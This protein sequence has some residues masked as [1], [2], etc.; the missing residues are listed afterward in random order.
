MFLELPLLLWMCS[1][2]L[3]GLEHVGAHGGL[4]VTRNVSVSVVPTVLQVINQSSAVTDGT[5]INEPDFNS[6]ASS[7]DMF[8]GK[9]STIPIKT[10]SEPS[11]KSKGNYFV[12]E[13]S[14]SSD[15]VSGDNTFEN[16]M[17]NVN[18]GTSRSDPQTGP[19][20]PGL[21]SGD[22]T[23]QPQGQSLSVS[24]GQ[25]VNNSVS[26][27]TENYFT[28]LGSP[29]VVHPSKPTPSP[30]ITLPGAG[31]INTTYNSPI[32]TENN[33]NSQTSGVKTLT[34]TDFTTA[35]TSYENTALITQI[36]EH[37]S[38]QT[39]HKG[40]ADHDKSN[41]MSTNRQS[42]DAKD[43]VNNTF[44]AVTENGTK[45]ITTSGVFMTSMSEGMLN[46]STSEDSVVTSI[47]GV[48]R[49]P[50]S[51]T[52][53]FVTTQVPLS[54]KG[55][56]M[57]SVTE[58]V[59]MPESTKTY[60]MLN[61][62]Q[63]VNISTTVAYSTNKISVHSSQ[64]S[65]HL[66]DDITAQTMTTSPGSTT[67][68]ITTNLTVLS[69]LQ[70][71]NTVTSH[72]SITTRPP[73]VTSTELVTQESDGAT[74]LVTTYSNIV[75]MQVTRAKD[76]STTEESF[77]FT[78]D[79][80]TYNSSSTLGTGGLSKTAQ[81]GIGI[82]SVVLFWII[83]GPLV[84][85]ICRLRDRAKAR[86]E[87]EDDEKPRESLSHN[88]MEQYIMTELARGREKM[89]QTTLTN[90]NEIHKLNDSSDYE[91]SVDAEITSF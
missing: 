14:G 7:K 56:T 91:Q 86:D 59:T 13:K 2:I 77:T 65:D 15:T 64:T 34:P 80:S 70:K 5:A 75:T 54:S 69:T 4:S 8:S 66:G 53:Q 37:V 67:Q 61:T 45:S 11:E 10:L 41:N 62:S 42:D 44:T 49:K 24:K 35:S 89:Y 55:Q 71:D 9:T 40:E 23:T 46:N 51:N 3:L 58:N 50:D 52:S 74:N 87:P 57:Q 29:D 72:M 6:S 18:N 38:R 20:T 73:G 27:D 82:G 90:E 48:T 21:S 30:L 43:A 36:S 16:D 19:M 28:T 32:G 17:V 26:A 1:C 79:T 60:L 31:A 88:L 63:S 78:Q 84:C 85:L 12:T 47:Q 25:E 76:D 39:V 33:T 83:L 22:R 81:I 68:S